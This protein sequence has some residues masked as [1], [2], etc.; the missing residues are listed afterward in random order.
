M[1]HF[2]ATF[3]NFFAGKEQKKKF[4]FF[5]LFMGKIHKK[6]EIKGRKIYVSS[7]PKTLDPSK[8]LW[9]TCEKQ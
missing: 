3:T 7:R 9:Y 5:T 6:K 8:I 4:G 2:W 1:Q